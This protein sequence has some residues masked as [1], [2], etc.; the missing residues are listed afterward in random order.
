MEA[1]KIDIA[2][3]DPEFVSGHFAHSLATTIRDMEYH[4]C[5]GR[6]FRHSAPQQNSARNANVT[7][8]LE[9]SDSPWLWM[10]DADM[11]VDKGHVMKLWIAANEHEADM[12]T[13]LAFIWKEG[14]LAVP[15]IFY[16]NDEGEMGQIPRHIPE[17]GTE[18]AAC[19]LA[20]V[21]IHRRV[22]EGLEAPRHPDYRWFDL[23]PNQD[24][25]I[26]GT[27]MTGVDV[28]FF[29]RARNAGFKLIVEP[30]AETWH[31]EDLA[32]N[33]SIWERQWEFQ[34]AAA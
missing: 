13:G 19:G 33:R 11:V 17:S 15:S 27:E 6:V 4:G 18:V 3:C 14:R 30:G 1:E 25:G 20:S 34:D 10:V 9:H 23:V 31:L 8:F 28:Q 5:A 2:W 29:K 16:E 7:E 26:N 32:V 21:L 22:F 12:V 24:I